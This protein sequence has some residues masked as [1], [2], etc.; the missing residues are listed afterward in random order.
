MKEKPNRILFV[1]TGEICQ[2]YNRLGGKESYRNNLVDED[3][4]ELRKS[5]RLRV[6][7]R[8]AFSG[9]GTE[10][11]GKVLNLSMDGCKI[12]SD[13]SVQKDD[14]LALR[15]HVPQFDYPIQ[16]EQATVRWTKGK[17]FGLEFMRVFPEGLKQLH[18]LITDLDQRGGRRFELPRD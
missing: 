14:V 9:E 2:Y 6:E 17:E 7:F 18:R 13:I 1:C 10:G 3:L 5:P 11:E 12:E 16:I 8:S 15:I 4:M